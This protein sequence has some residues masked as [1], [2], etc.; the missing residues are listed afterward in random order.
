MAGFAVPLLQ[1]CTVCTVEKLINQILWCLYSLLNMHY[2][3]K[4]FKQTLEI[5]MR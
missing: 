4:Y 2:T 1:T 5:L 3:K